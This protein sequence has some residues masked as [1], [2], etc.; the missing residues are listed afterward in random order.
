MATVTGRTVP[1]IDALIQN[2][3]ASAYVNTS[4]QLIVVQRD[5]DEVNAGTVRK[6]DLVIN[7]KDFGAK[8]DG[9]T[10]DTSAFQAARTELGTD[11]GQLYGPQGVYVVSDSIAPFDSHQGFHGVGYRGTAIKLANATNKTIFSTADDGVQRY[12]VKFSDF[13]IDGNGRNQS[14]TNKPLINIAGCNEVEFSN[15]Y[16]V[17]A[18]GDV[19]AIGQATG[20]IYCTVPRFY[21][22]I[23]RGDY[24]GD[25]L[26][27][28]GNAI[29][30]Q[31]GSSDVIA[32]GNDIGYFPNGSGLA[33]SGH[34]GGA[35][36]QNNVWQ[37]KFGYLLYQ[38]NRTRMVG[39]LA[40]YSKYF[41]F[42]IQESSD[43]QFIG[44]Q[45][46]ESS[47]DVSNLYDGF[48]FE[49]SSGNPILNTVLVGCRSMGTRH[50]NGVRL[51]SYV[52][53]IQLIA[54]DYTQNLSG[55]VY[56]SGTG[57]S[58]VTR[59]DDSTPLSAYAPLASPTFTG[60]PAAPTPSAG[61][62]TTKLATT[63]FVATSFAPK[64]SPV[65][66]GTPTAPTSV[67]ADDSTR[68]ATTAFV[69]DIT[70]NLTFDST[71]VTPTLGSGFTHQNTGANYYT[72][73]RKVGNFVTVTIA[74]T[75]A[76]PGTSGSVIF[77]LPGGYAPS[78]ILFCPLYAIL[79]S[80]AVSG[81]LINTSGQVVMSASSL[82]S[83]WGTITFPV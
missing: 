8:G 47:V 45:A 49:G 69:H 55:D 4:G 44:C 1:S 59:I 80:V 21:N 11:F 10:D 38:S 20:G 13:A 32:I 52:Q 61:D 83:Y 60:T 3:L 17:G 42:A 66:T 33:L 43:T 76:S 63:A 72:K 51:N 74:I 78:S 68:I 5:G 16:S 73:Y 37:C 46:R 81:A 2:L 82:T 40:D 18:R 64:A 34:N 75:M 67:V 50:R 35:L 79:G 39:N 36:A 48:W 6:S 26:Y 25:P 14:V 31:S 77:T 54:G 9:T 56:T 12:G 71:W 57:V 41:G 15:M 53:G 58:G 22:N 70:D 28:F 19:I 24:A 62:S 29:N 30:L 23:F 27:S 7:V 65:F